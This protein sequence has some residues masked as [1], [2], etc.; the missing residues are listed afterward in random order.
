MPRVQIK[1]ERESFEVLMRRFKRAVDKADV[2]RE[3]KKREVYEKPSMRRARNR[4]AAV[5]RAQR[6][7]M[8][9]PRLGQARASRK[10]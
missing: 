4:A 5:K 2:I 8:P 6:D 3:C 1:H 7:N 10:R 9:D